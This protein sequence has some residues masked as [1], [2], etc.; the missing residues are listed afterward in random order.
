[1]SADKPEPWIKT[2]NSFCPFTATKSVLWPK[3]NENKLVI[4]LFPQRRHYLMSQGHKLSNILEV[5]GITPVITPCRGTHYFGD[6]KCGTPPASDHSLPPG[7]VGPNRPVSSVGHEPCSAS[8]RHEH[9]ALLLKHARI[10]DRYSQILPG[11]RAVTSDLCSFSET[12][13]LSTRTARDFC[14]TRRGHVHIL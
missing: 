10:N 9:R 5:H 2:G 7:R 11:E 3:I 8:N 12:G 13:L 1:M 14:C 4:L 6:T